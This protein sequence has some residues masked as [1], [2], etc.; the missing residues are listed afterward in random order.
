MC[1][2]AA[3]KI[4]NTASKSKLLPEPTLIFISIVQSKLENKLEALSC[5]YLLSPD[6]FSSRVAH[7]QLRNGCSGEGGG[8]DQGG[9]DALRQ[10]PAGP[11]AAAASAGLH[12]RQR[13]L[14]QA[15]QTVSGPAS[16]PSKQSPRCSVLTRI[17]DFSGARP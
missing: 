14:R 15:R 13:S 7:R 8:G 16:E 10:E 6:L 5:T 4:L 9:R 2:S 3:H 17:S 1:N 11:S 12:R